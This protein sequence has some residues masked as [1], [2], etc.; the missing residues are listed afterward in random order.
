MPT[1]EPLDPQ[2]TPRSVAFSRKVFTFAGIYGVLVMAPNYFM[3]GWIG[4]HAAPPIT[5]PEYFYGF[6]GLA[7]AWQLIFLLIGRDPLRYRAAMIPA[8][9]EKA[10]FGVPA[11]VLYACGRLAALTLVPALIDLCLGVL[12][13]LAFRA[14]ARPE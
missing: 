1:N 8:V 5:H 12:F 2:R 7:L 6:I 3:E 10:A 14:T 4:R 9:L 13:V 11:L